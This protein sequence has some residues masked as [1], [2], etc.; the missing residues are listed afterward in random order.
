MMN[1]LSDLERAYK[2]N[3]G[4]LLLFKEMDPD[5]FDQKSNTSC[6][7]RFLTTMVQRR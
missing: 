4:E 1:S 5:L 6:P 7:L 2:V 3:Q